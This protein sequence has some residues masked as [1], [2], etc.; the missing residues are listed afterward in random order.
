MELR[1]RLLAGQKQSMAITSSVIQSIKLLKYGQEELHAFLREQE[2]KNPLIEIVSESTGA[3]PR[4]VQAVRKSGEVATGGNTSVSRNRELT[5]PRNYGIGR[6]A[7]SEDLRSIEETFACPTSLRD[8][9]LRQVELAFSGHAEQSIAIE[10][11]ESIEPDGYLRRELDEIAD[12]LGVEVSKTEAVLERVQCFEPCGV[13]ARDLAECLALQLTENGDLTTAMSALLDHIDLLAR[14][15]FE[16]LAEICNV[17]REHIAEMV[18]TIRELDPRPGRQFDGEP[19]IS[20]LPDVN[21]NVRQDGTFH[22]ELNTELLPKVLVNHDY[23]SEIRN[24]PGGAD[25]THFVADCMSNANW[26]TRN[27]EQR[28][29]TILKVATEIAKRQKDFFLR[30]VEH[31]SPLCQGDVADALGIHRSTVCR[32]ISNKYMMTNRGVF[33]LKFFFS[34]AIQSSEGADDVSSEAV[35]AKIRQMI[36]V[37]TAS[38]VLSDDAIMTALRR[39]GV[40]IARRT[41]A[42]YREMMNIPSSS[43]RKRRQRATQIEKRLCLASG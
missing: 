16:K 32:A 10:I 14:Y 43:I 31:V 24:C 26:L 41:V 22:I 30:G 15:D 8:Q 5:T 18:G 12:C 37:E 25:V 21:V 29:D 36:E 38:T 3:S 6:G 40:G 19:V 20:A 34:N 13:G 23:Y 42:K 11:V 1:P 33:E 39:D 9:L 7:P 28:A 35:R 4:P 17:D 2:E 27:L